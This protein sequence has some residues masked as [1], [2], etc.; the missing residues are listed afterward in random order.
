M[1]A[2]GSLH[3]EAELLIEPNGRLII[4]IDGQFEPL[5]IKPI[6]GNVDERRHQRRAHATPLEIIMHAH[7]KVADMSAPPFVVLDVVGRRMRPSSTRRFRS[8]RQVDTP[9]LRWTFGSGQIKKPVRGSAGPNSKQKRVAQHAPP[10]ARKVCIE[11]GRRTYSDRSRPH[12][13]AFRS[14]QTRSEL[15]APAFGATSISWTPS[16][17]REACHEGGAAPAADAHRESDG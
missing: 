2:K 14:A 9:L 6:V 10:V 17:Q 12:I 11:C 16:S 15:T 8:S 3:R 7:T 13:I 5:Q 1:T 4:H